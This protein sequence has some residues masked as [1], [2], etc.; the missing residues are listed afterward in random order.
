MILILTHSRDVTT[1]LLLD[2]F[3]GV[4]VFRANIDLWRDYRWSLEPEGFW[5]EDPV[6]RIC[7]DREVKAVYLRKLLFDPVYLDVPAEGSEEF[8]CREQVVHLWE[9]LRDLAQQDGRLALV[10]PS[11]LGR[12]SKIRQMRLAA[13]FFSVPQWQIRHGNLPE[14]N[15]P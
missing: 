8:W 14:T 5:I 6:G 3:Q 10:K 12:W 2:R 15:P 7:L 1:D 11:S 4:E 9:G 13:Q